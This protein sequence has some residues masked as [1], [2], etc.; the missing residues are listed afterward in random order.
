MLAFVRRSEG[1]RRCTG[2][3]NGGAGAG[4]PN[5]LVGEVLNAILDAGADALATKLTRFFRYCAGRGGGGRGWGWPL[6]AVGRGVNVVTMLVRPRGDCP[7]PGAGASGHILLRLHQRGQDGGALRRSGQD[8]PAALSCG[9]WRREIRWIAGM[10][11]SKGGKGGVFQMR[12]LLRFCRRVPNPYDDGG[13]VAE[14]MKVAEV[15]LQKVAL[16][17]RPD[18]RPCVPSGIPSSRVASSPSRSRCRR[19]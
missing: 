5:S 13:V 9:G 17:A 7:G 11:Q 12:V 15:S 4:G 8:S 14:R 10:K 19:M 1:R 6:G 3:G 2:E 18:C 16:L